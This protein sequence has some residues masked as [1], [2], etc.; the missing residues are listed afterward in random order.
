MFY[1]WFQNLHFKHF[2]LDSIYFFLGTI[3][4]RCW[5]IPGIRSPSTVAKPVGSSLWIIWFTPWCIPTMH[6]KPCGKNIYCSMTKEQQCVYPIFRRILYL[7]IVLC[8]PGFAFLVEWPCLSR[9]FSWLRWLWV[10]LLITSHML[11]NRMD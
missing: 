10:A 9:Q 11:W 1:D 2:Y 6:W 7:I 3:I 5:F 4:W 8:V